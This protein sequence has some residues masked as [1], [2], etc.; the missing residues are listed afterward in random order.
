MSKHQLS[1]IFFGCLLFVILIGVT[2]WECSIWWGIAVMLLW[3]L[4]ITIGSFFIQFNYHVTSVLSVKTTEKKVAITFDDGPTEYTSKALKLLEDYCAKATFFCIGKN[5]EKNKDLMQ[6]MTA[7]GH[8]IGN[9]TYSHD[10]RLGF[11]NTDEICDEIQRTQ[12]LIKSV[13][14]KYPKFYRPPFGVT[15]PAIR[16]A[17]K[18][19]KL[20][21]IG[22]SIRSL[23][24]LKNDE[25]KVFNRIVKRI[26]PGCIILLHDTSEKTINILERLLIYLKE[27]GY[28]SLTI[29]ELLKLEK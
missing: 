14:G 22:W 12:E 6:E 3:G 29:S 24:T 25:N 11:K 26:Q 2:F 28:E 17:I 23:D 21:S 16:R 18:H 19:T 8:D 20:V 5:V 10:E 27:N 7:L 4:V 9:H 1:Y 15:N 13:I